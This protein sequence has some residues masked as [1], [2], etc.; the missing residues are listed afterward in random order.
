VKL[1]ELHLGRFAALIACIIAS[2]VVAI[3]VTQ[4]YFPLPPT[5][6]RFAVDRGALLDVQQYR[7]LL[8]SQHGITTVIELVDAG[9][10]SR[11]RATAYAQADVVFTRGTERAAVSE[12]VT[13]ANVERIPVWLLL[14]RDRD[15]DLRQFKGGTV[16]YPQSQDFIP[17][18]FGNIVKAYGFD[19]KNFSLQPVADS[20]LLVKLRGDGVDLFIGEMR[21]DSDAIQSL[22]RD[23]KRHIAYLEFS[24]WLSKSMINHSRITMPRAT[25]DYTND[26]PNGPRSLLV[27]HRQL[28]ARKTMHPAL[29][30]A[31]LDAATQ[32]HNQST[33]ISKPGD[34]PNFSVNSSELSTIAAQYAQN[35]RPWA[36][37]VL[38]YWWAQFITLIIY[39]MVPFIALASILFFAL[40]KLRARHT[41]QLLEVMFGNLASLESEMQREL[42]NKPI[43][44]GKYLRHLDVIDK[45]AANLSVPKACHD[46]WLTLR[47]HTAH[48]RARIFEQRGR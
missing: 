20:E 2:A 25:I 46:R 33:L 34:F 5:Q 16:A 18:L 9:D 35:K 11:D 10:D 30:R 28:M 40:K 1:A 6:L 23:S 39:A 17:V 22:L 14:H 36:E 38:T 32:I 47:N 41:N 44:A 26:I 15:D 43:M 7:A 8:H 24:D 13:L 37:R 45:N 12:F 48:L 19:P 31:L 4:H 29:Q 3:L 27:A 21:A 42:L